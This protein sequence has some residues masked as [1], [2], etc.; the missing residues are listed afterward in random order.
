MTEPLPVPEITQMPGPPSPPTIPER[1]SQPAFPCA[2][3]QKKG[4]R[5][6]TMRDWFAAM[7]MQAMMN[8]DAIPTTIQGKTLT[9]AAYVVADA[10]IRSRKK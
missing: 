5:G 9:E 4:F 7:A 3:A 1:D 8:R 6:L 2:Y 10:M